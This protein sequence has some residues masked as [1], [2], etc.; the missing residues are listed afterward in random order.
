MTRA[1]VVQYRVKPDA[2]E[3]NETLVHAVF[4]E[5]A[6]KR[7]DGLSYRTVRVNDRT[8]IHLA[9]IDGDTNPLDQI[10]AFAAF[11]ATINERCDD[12]PHASRGTL[13]GNY[14]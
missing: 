2:V 14:P 1:V 10:D 12:G 8:F 4:A 13:V 9:V 5:L 7:P 3:E 11:T 6:Q